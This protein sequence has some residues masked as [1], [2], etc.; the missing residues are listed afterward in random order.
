MA[1]G[2][3]IGVVGAGASGL[4]A[5]IAAA[6]AG[7]RVTLFERG[8]E[9]GRKLLLTGN[10]R[11]NL[12]NRDLK[13]E[14]YHSSDPQKLAACLARY[15]LGET[16]AFFE[17]LGLLLRER[18]GYLYP[19][20]GQ[21]QAVREVLL[22]R[23]RALGV[24][25][26]TSAKVNRIRRGGPGEILLGWGREPEAAFDKVILSCGGQA[27]PRTGSD[28]TGYYLAR[29]LGHS[30]TSVYP[31]LVQLRCRESFLKQIAG[32]RAQAAAE[33]WA[34][35]T[36]VCREAGEVQFTD[37]G[38][39]GIPIFQ[40]SGQAARLLEKGPVRVRMDFLPWMDPRRDG[41]FWER[42]LERLGSAPAE[43]FFAGTLHKK[44]LLLLG[45]LAGLDRWWKKPAAE[46]PGEAM[47]RMFGLFRGLE[48]TVTDTNSFDQAQVCRGGV[49]MRE[50]DGNLESLLA[51]GVYFAGEL[52]DVDG[53]CGGYNLQWAW[54]SGLLT[55]TEAAK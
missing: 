47:G 51:P 17:E 27:A 46:V 20:C 41:D 48:L 36:F 49:D 38:V 19:A 43:D 31:A 53:R 29:Q 52:L 55:G 14:Y 39:S 28:G 2:K 15:G 5:S 8:E 45:E 6:R 26:K 44:L 12:G 33:L 54:T 18:D 40:L 11:C 10:G 16:L 35:S 4:A 25:V 9:P 42:R 30:V 37:Y 32:V 13:P 22:A 1:Q 24:E 34:G 23:A 50:V 21:A 7:A 3:R